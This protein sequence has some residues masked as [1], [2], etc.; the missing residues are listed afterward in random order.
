MSR[1]TLQR[2]LSTPYILIPALVIAIVLFL[3]IVWLL[4]RSRR[5]AGE[6][7]E[8]VRAELVEME[9]EHQFAA[10]AE[11]MPFAR[12]A[13]AAA[14]EAAQVFREYIGL[15]VLAIYAGREQQERLSNILPKEESAG[16]QTHALK[17][18]LPESLNADV[19]GNF[20]KPQQTKLGFFTGELSAGSF[21]TGSLVKE[22]R[23][24]PT[25]TE[26]AVGD[27]AASDQ[28]APPADQAS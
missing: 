1:E 8:H 4:V 25:T 16:V 28:A 22:P 14:Q 17:A 15:P 27:E 5:G 6:R 11:Q 20:W 2:F 13:A 3:I 23:T 24:E 7:E 19:L 10:A 18:L 21:V 12:A 26:A 9:R